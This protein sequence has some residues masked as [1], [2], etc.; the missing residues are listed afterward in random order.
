MS[1]S[2]ATSASDVNPKR[3]RSDDQG[4]RQPVHGVQQAES[5]SVASTP[6]SFQTCPST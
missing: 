2:D 4:A 6:I 5:I 3:R 1:G